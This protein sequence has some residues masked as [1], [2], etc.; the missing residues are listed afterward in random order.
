MARIFLVRHGKT[1]A[2]S[3][4]KYQGQTD[5]PLN[6]TGLKQAALLAKDL[7]KIH[8]NR[9]YTSNLKRAKKTAEVLAKPHRLKVRSLKDLAERNFGL[10]ENLTFKDIQKKY[11]NLYKQWLKSPAVKIPKAEMLS[12]FQKRILRGLKKILRSL[13]PAE[14]ILIVAHGGSNRIILSHFLKQDPAQSFWQIKQDN[15]CLNIIEIGNGYQMVSLLNYYK[16][17]LSQRSIK[18]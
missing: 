13:K 12:T 1:E 14:N 4:L 6:S 10:W 2:N 16:E 3:Q 18:Y 15:C 9:I 5:T 17:N 11:K 8:F 7:Q